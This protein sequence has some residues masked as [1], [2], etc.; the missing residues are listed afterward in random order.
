MPDPVNTAP[1]EK[2]APKAEAVPVDVEP[3]TTLD[4]F[5]RGLSLHDSRVELI[6]GFH[7]QMRISGKTHATKT[8]YTAL[9]QEFITAPA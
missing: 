6:S 1:A 3:A 8:E 5:C 4:D 7:M 9:F 2:P